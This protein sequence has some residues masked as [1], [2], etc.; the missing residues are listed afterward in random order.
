MMIDHAHFPKFF[1]AKPRCTALI[2]SG[3]SLRAS[4]NMRPIASHRLG[5]VTNSS[6]ERRSCGWLLVLLVAAWLM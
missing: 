4:R 1:A 5:A 6:L 3:A 2:T